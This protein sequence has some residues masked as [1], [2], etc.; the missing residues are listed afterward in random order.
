MIS[1]II[2]G[3]PKGKGRPRMNTKTGRAYTPKDT[4]LYE[5]LVRIQYQNCIGQKSLEG[6]IR[7]YITCYYSMPKSM[8]KA[9]REKALH[10]TLRPTKKPDLDNVCKIVLDSL[11]G[12]AYKDDSQVVEIIVKKYYSEQPLIKVELE[13]INNEKV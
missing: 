12:L 9:K 11:N 1:F 2:P 6:E 5:N 8:S 7:A 13:E 3:E 4:I 10:G